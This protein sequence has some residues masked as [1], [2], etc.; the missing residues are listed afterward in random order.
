V[1][2]YA[3]DGR[4]ERIVPMPVKHPTCPAF[5]GP[6][7]RHLFVISSRLDHTAEEL[8]RTPQ[9]GGLFACAP[10]VAGLPEGRVRA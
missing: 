6:D 9:A 3:P 2:R 4:I 8:A 10:G 5:G 7:L 1:V